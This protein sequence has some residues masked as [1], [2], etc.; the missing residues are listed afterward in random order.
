MFDE[1]K[2]IFAGTDAPTP[3]G[4]VP[5]PAPQ[6]PAM[7]APPPTRLPPSYGSVPPGAMAPAPLLPTHHSG[8][9]VGKVL[10]IIV[11]AL[12]I[13]GISGFFAYRLMVQ[14]STE[15]SVVNAVPDTGVT[16]ETENVASDDQEDDETTPGST[17]TTTTPPPPTQTT[18]PSTLLDSDGDGLTNAKELEAGTSVTKADTDGDGLGDREEVEV[19]GTDPRKVDT[20]GDSYLDG[21]EVAGGYNPNGTGRLFVVPENN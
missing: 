1:P 9:G 3:A 8:I 18:N 7:I 10:L 19:Y 20:D 16:D 15:G 17:A 6:S 5:P 11:V 12:L 21:Q 13:L 2:D 4:A 14:P